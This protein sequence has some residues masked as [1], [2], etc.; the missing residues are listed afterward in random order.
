MADVRGIKIT[1]LA[2]TQLPVD[3]P[4]KMKFGV[5]R[6]NHTWS[7]DQMPNYENPK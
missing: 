1:L 7:G 3:M 6:Q 5:R 4:V 2:I